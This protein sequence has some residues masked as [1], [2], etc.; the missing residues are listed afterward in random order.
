LENNMSIHAVAEVL[1]R[2]LEDSAFAAALEVDQA[3]LAGYDLSEEEMVALRGARSQGDELKGLPLG[4]FRMVARG[5]GQ[6]APE[7]R[8]RL[9]QALAAKASPGSSI[10]VTGSAQFQ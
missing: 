7:L 1:C 10:P 4:A 2:T 9:N 3:S 8:Q 6:L 5:V